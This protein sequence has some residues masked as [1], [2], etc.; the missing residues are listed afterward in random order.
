MELGPAGIRV[1]AVCPGTV[2]GP[3]MD[4]V[5][6]READA[7]GTSEEAVRDGYKKLSAMGSFVTGEDIADSVAFLCSPSAAKVSGQVVSV[8]GYCET[9]VN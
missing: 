3:R 4:G 8:D 9:N 5:I 6:A 7:R 1:N 2:A